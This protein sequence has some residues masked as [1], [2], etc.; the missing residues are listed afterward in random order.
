MCVVL[1][2]FYVCLLCLTKFVII[3]VPCILHG[4]PEYRARV[5]VQPVRAVTRKGRNAGQNLMQYCTPFSA[6]KQGV[7]ELLRNNTATL[8]PLKNAH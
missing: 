5:H 4:I 8:H 2:L 3:I 1:Y 6:L 7:A